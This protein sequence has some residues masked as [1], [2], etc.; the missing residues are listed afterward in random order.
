MKFPVDSN[1]GSVITFSAPTLRPFPP[2][3]S[4]A[5]DVPCTGQGLEVQF[6]SSV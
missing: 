4:D 6:Q 1:S 3:V 5:Y 2:R